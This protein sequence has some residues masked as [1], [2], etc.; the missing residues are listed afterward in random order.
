M[1][2]PTREHILEAAAVL[3][4]EHGFRGTTTR[5]ITKLMKQEESLARMN[6]EEIVDRPLPGHS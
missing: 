3:Y 1:A 6:E 5:A 2:Q 4:A